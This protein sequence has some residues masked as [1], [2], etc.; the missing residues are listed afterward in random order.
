MIPA[1]SI[2]IKNSNDKIEDL[3][4]ALRVYDKTNYLKYSVTLLLTTG[5]IIMNKGLDSSI[6][7]IDFLDKYNK[8]GSL[9][10][11]TIIVSREVDFDNSKTTIATQ[12]F[13]TQP[14]LFSIISKLPLFFIAGTVKNC[15]IENDY[16]YRDHLFNNY[17]QIINK[18]FDR[19]NDLITHEQYFNNIRNL[20]ESNTQL[21]DC[22]V[23]G[24]FP[25]TK[26][27]SNILYYNKILLL[28]DQEFQVDFIPN[29][30]KIDM[31]RHYKKEESEISIIE[32]T[33]DLSGIIKKKIVAPCKVG[34]L[35]QF[36]YLS[37]NAISTLSH[38]FIITYINEESQLVY[39]RKAF[40]D[41]R[42]GVISKT[43]SQFN[44]DEDFLIFNIEIK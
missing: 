10:N 37:R 25:E 44:N 31:S 6:S 22:V 18:N 17:L 7:I 12:P 24:V 29:K 14:N 33:N 13:C 41:T 21:E 2:I 36:N 28:R 43:F 26:F 23:I 5:S 16:S 8:N 11:A 40:A 4:K 32:E 27:S 1:S 19:D 35:V 20:I 30:T 38:L 3:I 39:M 9:Q 42:D 15:N 34:Q